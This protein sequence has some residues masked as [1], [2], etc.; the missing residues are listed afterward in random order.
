MDKQIDSLPESDLVSIRHFLHANPELSGQEEHTAQFILQ[1]LKSCNPNRIQTGIGG[2]GLIAEFEGAGPGKTILF[3]ADM[4]ALPIQENHQFAHASRAKGVSHTCGH[5]GHTTVLLGLA[6]CLQ[7]QPLQNGKVVLLFQ[8]AEETGMGA[9][10]VLEDPESKLQADFA[11]AFHNLPGYPL[12]QIVLKD[13]SFTASVRSVCI[14]LEGITAHAGE[15]ENGRNPALALAQIIQETSLLSNNQVDRSD[16]T[17]ITPVYIRMGEIAYGVSAGSG[18]LHLT[19]RT[20][21]ERE[22]QLLS[23][24]IESIVRHAADAYQLGYTLEWSQ[25][26]RA[27]ENHPEAMQFLREAVSRAGLESTDR[28]YPFKWGEDFGLFT[29]QFK[30]A[31]FGIGSGVD[32][33]ALHHP[34]YDFPDQ[35]IPVGIKIFNTL[36]SRILD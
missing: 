18:E 14:R 24:K 15:P 8:P 2:H 32:C 17:L 36:I 20:W 12:G 25:H 23:D 13:H 21:T 35:I 10:Q 6:R 31:M 29:Q 34:D 19:I 33:P 11:F 26:F 16:F 4:D 9:Q 1:H 28:Q 27:N 5:D 30:G 3:R 7:E 22:L